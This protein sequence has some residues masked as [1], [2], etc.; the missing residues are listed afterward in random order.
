V[1]AGLGGEGGGFRG[2]EEKLG[3]GA[4]EDM[5]SEIPEIYRVE[6]EENRFRRCE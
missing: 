2:Y 5:R 3:E 1:R 4:G 6:G